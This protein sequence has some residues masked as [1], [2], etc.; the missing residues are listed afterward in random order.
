MKIL[1]T[2][3]FV[4]LSIPVLAQNEPATQFLTE[5]DTELTPIAGDYDISVSTPKCSPPAPG[6]NTPVPCG[7][8]TTVFVTYE[9]KECSDRVISYSKTID[10]QD[11]TYEVLISAF[12]VSSTQSKEVCAQTSN[13]M[14]FVAPEIV[15]KENVK[16]T[17]VGV[18]NL[19]SAPLESGDLALTPIAANSWKKV[20]QSC[21][22]GQMCMTVEST[23]V[24]LNYRLL[25]CLD[26]L[27]TSSTVVANEDGSYDVL[28]TALNIRNES[29]SKV[30]CI[31]MPSVVETVDVSL[32]NV[33]AEKI[34]VQFVGA[35]Q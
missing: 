5:F 18:D 31:A 11:G 32:A 22:E 9:V 33:P 25:G 23:A 15:E 7:P 28:I 24:E 6:N 14:I 16:V 34:N 27:A 29:S 8:R 20:K 1:T 26:R 4:V 21:P 30:K 12:N 10:N 2:F 19:V 17:F 3:L 13:Q 35:A